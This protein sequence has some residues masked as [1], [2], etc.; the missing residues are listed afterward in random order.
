M[1]M[2]SRIKPPLGHDNGW[3]WEQAAAGDLTIQRCAICQT[4]RHPPRPMCSECRSMEWDFIKST[5][6]GTVASFTVLHH[7]QFP[8]YEYPLIIVL[9]DLLE[10]TRL[11]AQLRE[12]DRDDVQFG[13]A[14]EAFIHEDDDGFKI[15]MFRPANASQQ[16]KETQHAD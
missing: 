6:R 2:P 14:V 11:V 15:P 16:A 8:G 5:G 4:L 10:G 9:V 12:C 3:W 7:P 1:N 13:M